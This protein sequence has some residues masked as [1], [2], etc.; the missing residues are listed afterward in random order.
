[1]Q[2]VNNS[3]ARK[4]RIYLAG[5]MGSGKSTVGPILANTIGYTFADLDRLIEAAEGIPVTAIFRTKGEGYFRG[6]ERE[7]VRVASRRP[8]FVLAL[9]GGT[10]GDP[11]NFDVLIGTGI[12]VYLR[13][14]LDLLVLRLQHRQ[15]RPL[16]MDDE[17]NKLPPPLL[18]ER[19]GQLLEQREPLYNRASVIVD[20]DERRVGITVDR[21]V[22]VLHPFLR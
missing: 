20:V 19:I 3:E 1:M 11:E 7:Q 10:L 15:D 13:V 8:R 14:S 5:F 22:K 2:S 4:E 12:L 16:L 9:G 17:G 21:L 6:L 18:R